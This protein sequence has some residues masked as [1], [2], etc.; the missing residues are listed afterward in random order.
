MSDNI[1]AMAVS[2][3]LVTEEE[4]LDLMLPYAMPEDK[5]SLVY[6]IFAVHFL[7]LHND[8][9]YEYVMDAVHN[10]KEFAK[11][12]GPIEDTFEDEGFLESLVKT[13]GDTEH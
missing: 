8:N 13:K 4:E 9:F 12:L 7:Y 6:F 5:D 3:L 11:S 1:E 2:A 10:N